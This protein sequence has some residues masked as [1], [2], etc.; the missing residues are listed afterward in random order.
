[1]MSES[2]NNICVNDEFTDE[3]TTKKF[4]SKISDASDIIKKK[5]LLTKETIRT[6]EYGIKYLIKNG[7]DIDNITDMEELE[8][9]FIKNNTSLNSKR[10][11]I[12]SLI[13][14][15]KKKQVSREEELKN[16]EDIEKRSQINETILNTNAFKEELCEENEKLFAHHQNERDKNKL[17]ERE[18]E[19]YVDWKVILNVHSEF[20]KLTEIQN[21]KETDT[22]FLLLSVYVLQHGPRR[23]SDYSN[24]IYINNFNDFTDL[25]QNYYYECDGTGYFIFNVYKTSHTYGTVQISLTEPMYNLITKYINKYKINI[26]DYIFKMNKKTCRD[27]LHKIF[28]AYI[29][30]KISA[31]ILR[32]SYVTFCRKNNLLNT[33]EQQRVLAYRM[34]H[35]IKMQQEY[36]RDTEYV[37][38]PLNNVDHVLFRGKGRTTK[39]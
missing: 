17:T 19:V 35:S 2:E 12:N 32:N 21:N 38:I 4:D 15:L 16:E 33:S 29:N 30:K 24:I 10:R 26:N 5:R 13:N 34:S 39:Y 14:Y 3:E 9:L 36:F 20:E 22:A 37:D 11:L 18:E 28:V 6:Y 7:I 23:L 8:N 31:K 1:M 27:I 25:S